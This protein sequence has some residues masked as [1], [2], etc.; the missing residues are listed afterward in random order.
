MKTTTLWPPEP[1]INPRGAEVK[2][3]QWRALRKDA[4]KRLA[5]DYN[6]IWHWEK[7]MS[8]VI[9]TKP[10]MHLCVCLHSLWGVCEAPV[11]EDILADDVWI[12]GDWVG[13]Q[14][15]RTDRK[16]SVSYAKCRT[17]CLSK[18]WATHKDQRLS[19]RKVLGSA[20][21]LLFCWQLYSVSL[22]LFL[23]YNHVTSCSSQP[24]RH[25]LRVCLE[26]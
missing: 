12:G 23:H 24:P 20:K 11:G 1:D 7:N 26:R 2:P 3:R 6:A 19:Y 15:W 4:K 5:E 16:T 22:S 14:H 25:G 18:C 10:R 9:N 21:L 8:D 17:V 13:E